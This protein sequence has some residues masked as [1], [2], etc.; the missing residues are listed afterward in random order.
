MLG[1][2]QFKFPKLELQNGLRLPS[3][4]TNKRLERDLPFS[5]LLPLLTYFSDHL[6]T[7][8]TKQGRFLRH[9][10]K[11]GRFWGWFT[12]D[13]RQISYVIFVCI[14]PTLNLHQLIGQSIGYLYFSELLLGLLPTLYSIYINSLHICARR[15]RYQQI[16]IAT[17]EEMPDYKYLRVGAS[18]MGSNS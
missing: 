8:P 16:T 10:R 18:Y 1:V 4:P 5:L 9:L 13:I 17:L 12:E 15:S 2:L 6:C 11:Q 7:G 14:F 3:T